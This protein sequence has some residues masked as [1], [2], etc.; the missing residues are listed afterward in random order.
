MNA[1]DVAIVGTAALLMILG[2]RT[3]ILR[4]ASGIGGLVLGVLMAA[5]YSAEADAILEAYLEGETL[6]RV[7]AFVAVVL[8]VTIATRIAAALVKSLL[9]ALV[10]GWVDHLAG[11]V[12]GVALG[13]V[14][15][16]TVVYLLTGADLEPTRDAL[17]AS[18]LTPQVSRLSLVAA[19]KPWCASLGPAEGRD[20]CTDLGDLTNQLVGRHIPDKVKGL[21]G[22]DL[23]SVAEAVG[24][25][26]D[27]SPEDIADLARGE[28]GL[29]AFTAEGP[30]TSQP[31]A[32]TATERPA[33]VEVLAPTP[34][35]ER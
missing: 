6:R 31:N 12:A 27:I 3:G 24:G 22:Q 7:V 1:V 23:G 34:L 14:L 2:L 15:T 21:F 19:E 11:G 10:L 33:V 30:S 35:A 8:A 4:P 32:G 16:G 5:H 25:A 28:G 13:L 20:G 9:S 17:A 18:K 29:A 26:L